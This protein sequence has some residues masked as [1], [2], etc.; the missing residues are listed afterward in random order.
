MDVMG[1]L[2]GIARTGDGTTDAQ[3]MIEVLLQHNHMQAV[4]VR[5]VARV[6]CLVQ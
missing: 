3:R 6:R 2:A 1:V 4:E 5:C